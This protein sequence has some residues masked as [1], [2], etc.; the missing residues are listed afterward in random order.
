MRRKTLCE[1][2]RLT[3]G[4]ISP[5]LGLLMDLGVDVLNPVQESA[6]DLELVRQRTQGRMALQGGINSGLIVNG[7]VDRIREEV[8]HRIHQ[9][10]QDGGYFCSPDQAM[11][12][13]KEHIRA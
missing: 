3:C 1:S 7:P 11:P 9:L 2:F 5:I 4:H 6:N 8:C 12:F 10:G 13:P